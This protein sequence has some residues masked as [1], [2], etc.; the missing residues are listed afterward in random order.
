MSN[1]L[2][3]GWLP[4]RSRLSDTT[5]W[6]TGRTHALLR[7]AP[8]IGVVVLTALFIW[9]RVIEIPT[10]RTVPVSVLSTELA[11][12]TRILLLGLPHGHGGLPGTGTRAVL[13]LPDGDGGRVVRLAGHLTAVLPQPEGALLKL[14][15]APGGRI[16]GVGLLLLPGENVRLLD[17]LL[18]KLMVE[19]GSQS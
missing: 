3:P 8:L 4:D 12:E 13:R 10:P 18:R 7:W 11:E 6:V 9:L 16:E 15:V 1:A 14:Q 19:G 5:D 2:D 17:I